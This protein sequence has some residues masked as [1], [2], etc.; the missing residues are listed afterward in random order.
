MKDKNKI[1]DLKERTFQLSL[2]IIY[3]ARKIPFNSI[4]NIIIKQLV[5]SIT[6]I[7]A[8]YEEA[9]EAYPK[10]DF[11]YKIGIAKKEAKESKYWLSLIKASFKLENK[12]I[13]LCNN[14]IKETIELTKISN[15]I[16][17]NRSS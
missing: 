2:N 15:S 10:P 14:F 9:D 12:D 4:D 17:K 7:G 13:E 1:Y 6:S 16:L 8:N 11:F 5:R 3:F